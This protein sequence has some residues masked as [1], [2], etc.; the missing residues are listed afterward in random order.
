MQGESI[1]T[2]RSQL[3]CN[4]ERF[5][6][7]LIVALCASVLGSKLFSN[8]FASF[9]WRWVCLFSTPAMF[10]LSSLIGFLKKSHDETNGT[11]MKT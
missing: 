7:N 9:S 10:L 8:L 6:V 3:T 4:K 2:S 11:K 1:S 5:P